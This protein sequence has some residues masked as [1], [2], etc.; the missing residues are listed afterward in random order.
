MR[1]SFFSNK[2]I[3]CKKRMTSV[4]GVP[5]HR[6]RSA[7]HN[8]NHWQSRWF[9]CYTKMRSQLNRSWLR[10]FVHDFWSP[11]QNPIA[12]LTKEGGFA[13]GCWEDG[14]LSL[15]ASMCGKFRKRLHNRKALLPRP[16][17]SQTSNG[18]CLCQSRRRRRY[19]SHYCRGKLETCRHC[20]VSREDRWGRCF[21]VR[22]H[23]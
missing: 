15:V 21:S 10:V 3:Q 11:R 7:W 23:R 20:P 8:Q 9:S 13:M 14:V 17:F 12:C 5:A 6:S 22:I 19:P 4:R 2:R 16:R 18:R 1:Q